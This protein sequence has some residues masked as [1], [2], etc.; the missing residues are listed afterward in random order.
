MY[1]PSC[2]LCMLI[3]GSILWIFT[4]KV[5]RFITIFSIS[6]YFIYFLELNNFRW[7]KASRAS[8][9]IINCIRNKGPE[10][11]ILINLP[12]ELEGAFVFR[13]GFMKALMINKLDTAGVKII[14]LLKRTE[15]LKTGEIIP[16]QIKD[17]T[18]SIY[19]YVRIVNHSNGLLQLTNSQNNSTL[20]LRKDRNLVYYW[21]KTELVRLF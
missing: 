4:S 11:I 20:D 15:Y 2:F 6:A 10:D 9:A 17:S 5:Y 19:P 12:D 8:R 3:A 18:I 1:F 7:V 16:V 21:N 13:N 14:N